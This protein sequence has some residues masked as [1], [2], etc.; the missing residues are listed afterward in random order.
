MQTL[1]VQTSEEEVTAF[2]EQHRHQEDKMAAFFQLRATL[3]PVVETV[4]LLDR[5][6]F[7]LEQVSFSVCVYVCACVCAC[8]RMCAC[9]HE[10]VCVCVYVWVGEYACVCVCVRDCVCVSGMCVS[11]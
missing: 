4:V 6:L 11:V 7:L 2:H 9:M 8:V 10:C 3:A 1:C 5:L